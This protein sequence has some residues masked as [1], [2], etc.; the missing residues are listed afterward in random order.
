MTDRRTVLLVI[1]FLGTFGL[2]LTGSVAWVAVHATN[3]PDNVFT[4]LVSITSAV[5]GGL[6][7][8][9]VHTGSTPP[10]DAVSTTITADPEAGEA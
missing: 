4:A 6:G 1:G 8:M 3:V 5:V 7:A 9:L 2:I 10:T